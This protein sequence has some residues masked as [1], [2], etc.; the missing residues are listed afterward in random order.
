MIEVR[1][2]SYV[3]ED[4]TQ[5]LKDINI[6]GNKGQV[7]GIIGSNG[8]GK[9]TLFL[10]IMGI[11]RPKTGNIFY[12]GKKLN[13]KKSFIRNYRKE[14]NIVFQNPDQ[15]LFY[16][17]VYDDI[18]FSLRNLGMDEGEIRERVSKALEDVNCLDLVNKPIHFLS[19]GQKKRISIAGI[20]AL[21]G[22]VMLMDEPTSGL[23]PQ[24][25]REM[26]SVIEK[27]SRDRKI[28]ISSHDMDLIYE[29]CDYIYVINK[30]VITASGRPEEVF[31]ETEILEAAQLNKPWLVK[32][33][34]T[35]EIPLFKTEED[36]LNYRLK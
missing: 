16:S 3:Y 24:M 18:A 2:L 28:L 12:K 6:D 33:H 8:S 31:R 5:A 13:Y 17:D 11:L 25:T 34:E 35:L 10:N 1:N 30:G 20:L 21:D 22:K 32:I 23:D 14:V 26:K 27:I 15:Q 9:S 4:G 19:Y 7:I 36:F 29:I